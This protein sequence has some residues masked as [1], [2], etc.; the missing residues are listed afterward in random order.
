MARICPCR[1]R[2]VLEGSMAF[3]SEVDAGSLK[4]TRQNRRVEPGSDSIRTE[5]ALVPL[6]ERA[7]LQRD[8]SP[9]GQGPGGGVVRNGLG[10]FFCYVFGQFHRRLRQLL[11]DPLHALAPFHLAP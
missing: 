1:E 11:G 6:A 5:K 10:Q 2:R 4:K 9:P 3:S 8:N 7:G